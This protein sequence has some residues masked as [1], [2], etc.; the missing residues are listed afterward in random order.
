LSKSVEFLTKDVVREL[1]NTIV[2][3]DTETTGFSQY[4]DRIVEFGAIKLVNG[5]QV[6]SMSILINPGRHI[7]DSVVKVHGIDDKMVQDE[8]FEDYY[9]PKIAEFLR[10]ASYIVG[11]NVAFD[12]RFLE[13]MFL[14]NG[15]SF[16]CEY[17]DTLK[18]AKKIFKKAPDYKLT[19]LAKYLNIEIKDAHRALADVETTVWVLRH[20]AY[21]VMKI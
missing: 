17:I 11:H 4:R 7:P 14:R 19:T 6:D 18:F 15:Y 5:K 10:G 1:N 16:D 20:L 2:V 3:L 21:Q 9:A 12:I 13:Q 8:P